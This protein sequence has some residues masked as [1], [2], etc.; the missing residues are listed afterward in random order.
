MVLRLARENPGWGY[1][2]IHAELAG[3]GY[4]S[5]RRRYGRS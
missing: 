3:L 2:R 1:H 4:E 5:R